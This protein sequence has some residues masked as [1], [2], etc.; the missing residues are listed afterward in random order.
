M[1]EDSTVETHNAHVLMTNSSHDADPPG[2]TAPI[3]NSTCLANGLG[4][5]S[6]ELEDSEVTA[7]QDG[8]ESG[9]RVDEDTSEGILVHRTAKTKS[10][11]KA[12][13]GGK[14]GNQGRFHGAELEYLASRM[15]EYNEIDKGTSGRNEELDRF[16]TDVQ[17]AFWEQFPWEMV[18][19]G[20][21]TD[22]AAL[23]HEE[24]V[25]RTNKVRRIP[26]HADAKFISIA[27]CSPSKR[28]IAIVNV[29]E[30]RKGP[31]LGKRHCASFAAR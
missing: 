3:E 12:A 28:G 26:R 6:Q 29:L 13:Q 23:S 9:E 24:V 14:P 7:G 15:D 27:P 1:P 30:L 5:L 17:S 18:R 16:W 4:T 10:Q 11:R 8:G 25:K 22:M 20:M 21:G 19:S 2:D 31:V